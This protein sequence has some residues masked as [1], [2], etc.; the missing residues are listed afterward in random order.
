MSLS[1][2]KTAKAARKLPDSGLQPARNYA[3][4]D[5]GTQTGTFKGQPK[6]PAPE[7]MF[8][9]E[10][11]KFMHTYKEEEGPVP[12]TILQKYTFSNGA[13]AK[14]PKML[15]SWGR[16]PKPMEKLNV[17]PYLGQYCMLNISHTENGEYANI[18]SVNPFMAE[19]AKPKAYHTNVYFDL[20]QF[21]WEAFYTLPPYAQK[22][23]RQCA[24]WPK[25]ISKNP[26]PIQQGYTNTVIDGMEED[27]PFKDQF[28]GSDPY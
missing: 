16:L 27:S 9:F 10:I 15:Q 2:D 18:S 24:D 28:D 12:C 21:T 20:D 17:K 7:V 13:K 3:I 6:A 8:C 19:I 4:I 14:L 26:E 5:L 25:I 23:I 11:T 1:P 22:L